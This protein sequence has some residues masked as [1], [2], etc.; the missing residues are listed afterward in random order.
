MSKQNKIDDTPENWDDRTLGADEEFVR[1]AEEIDASSI[2]E[3]VG[4]QMISIR[5]QKTLLEDLKVIAKIN[6]IG[7]Q[8]LIK[9][10]LKRFT[11]AEKKIIIRD[12]YACQEREDEDKKEDCDPSQKI[13]M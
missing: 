10:I 3:A 9:Q 11:D 1:V 7:Y 2:D 12:Y 6:G 13:A 8:P 5:L 4:L